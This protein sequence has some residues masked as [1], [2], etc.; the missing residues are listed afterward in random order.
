MAGKNNRFKLFKDK[1]SL[2][3]RYSRM[4]NGGTTEIK[5]DKL[6]WWERRDL[7]KNTN[8]DIRIRIPEVFDGRPDLL[9]FRIYRNSSLFW[10]ILQYNNI[11]D[12]EE[13]FTTGKEIIVPARDRTVSSIVNRSI[14][15][16]PL[17]K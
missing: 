8:T 9:A 13:E 11:V 6:G 7:Q 10:L 14:R 12:I 4:L 17:R 2:A 5:G 1:T 16:E 3:K 15:K